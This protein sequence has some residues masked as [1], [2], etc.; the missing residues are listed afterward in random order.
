MPNERLDVALAGSSALAAA[1]GERVARDGGNAVDA[2]IAAIL[3]SMTTEPSIVG[4]GAGGFVTVMP[5]DGLPVT[6]DGYIE[7]PG[8]GL[9]DDR[10]GGGCRHVHVGYGGGVDT[11]VG[12]GSVGTPGA[13]AALEEASVR[14]GRLPWSELVSPAM[15]HAEAGFPLPQVSYDYLRDAHEEIYGWDP[16]SYVVLHDA[17]GRLHQA[18]QTIHVDHLRESL[19]ALSEGSAALYGG[20]LGARIVDAVQAGGG[21]LTMADLEAYRTVIREP[22]QARL[23]HWSFWTNPPPALGGLVL[24]AMLRL[25]EGRARQGWDAA[26]IEHLVRVQEAVL[27]FRAEHL[28]DEDLAKEAERLLGV[29]GLDALRALIGSPSTVQASAVDSAGYACSISVSSGYGSGMMPPGTGIWLNNCLGEIE[30]NPRGLHADRPGR[31]LTSNMAPTVGR[32]DDGAVIAIASPGADRI[33]TA[34]LQVLV[35]LTNTGLSLRDAVGWPRVHVE[36]S[37]RGTTVAFEDG[38]QVEELDLPLRR[39]QERSMFFGGV[40]V[41]VRSPDGDMSAASD[42]RRAGG[43]VVV[44]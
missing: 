37:D 21:L 9:P 28:G 44:Q 14:Y 27:S 34:L 22:L 36:L 26:E 16:N 31:R 25:M 33:T 8:R 42:P 5:P 2:A 32:R 35:N 40:G 15:D 23:G 3:V 24:A 12:P 10:F 39:F 4:L 18:G 41:A 6:L 7:M 17:R 30:L 20:P 38:A 19:A 1:A 13:L 43:A 11:V 29:S